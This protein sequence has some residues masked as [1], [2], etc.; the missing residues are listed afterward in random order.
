MDH[1]RVLVI[2]HVKEFVRDAEIRVTDLVLIDAQE[3]VH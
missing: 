3:H 1:V 2:I